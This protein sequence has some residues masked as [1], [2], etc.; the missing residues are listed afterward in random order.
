MLFRSFRQLE[1]DTLKGLSKWDNIVVATGGGAPCFHDNMTYINSSG[2]SVYLKTDPNLLLQRLLLESEKRPLLRGR[3]E[4]DLLAFIE[5]KVSERAAFYE[6][7]DIII[8]QNSNEQDVAQEILTAIYE[9]HLAR[10][11]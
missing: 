1:S 2:I 11:N 3:S 5:S 6:Q 9:T 7:A 10:K 4:A 8:S